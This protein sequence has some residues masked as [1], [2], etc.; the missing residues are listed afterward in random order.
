MHEALVETL[1]IPPNG[2]FQVLTA[3]DG[4]RGTLRHGDHLGIRRDEGIVYVAITL[5]AGRSD[6]P[7]LLTGYRGCRRPVR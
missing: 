3:H 2:H 4:T 1:G 5:R 7:G 6:V